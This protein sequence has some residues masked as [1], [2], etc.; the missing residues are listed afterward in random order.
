MDG[1]YYFISL[2]YKNYRRSMMESELEPVIELEERNVL[3]LEER[4]FY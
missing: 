3:E 1:F 2:K 4:M